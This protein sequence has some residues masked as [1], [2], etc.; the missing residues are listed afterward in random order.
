MFDNSIKNLF[1]EGG[2][3]MYSVNLDWSMKPRVFWVCVFF[4]FFNKL[5]IL[6]KLKIYNL[7]YHTLEVITKIN[8]MYV[9]LRFF[10]PIYTLIIKIR[11]CS[12][13]H[14]IIW[15]K[16]SNKI[17]RNTTQ[18]STYWFHLHDHII[19]LRGNRLRAFAPTYM[20]KFYRQ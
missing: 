1:G 8:L 3:Y 10:E 2:G 4:K 12:T 5:I 9:I 17:N 15:C 6:D 11:V 14:I 7:T 13:F 18:P 16:C 19:K 20:Y